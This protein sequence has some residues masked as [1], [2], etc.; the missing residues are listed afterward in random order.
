MSAFNPVLSI[1]A[2]IAEALRAHGRAGSRAAVRARVTDL[3]ASVGLGDPDRIRRAFPHELSGGQLQRAMIAMAISGE[4]EILIADEPT[5][6]LDVTVQ[7]GI[8]DLLR[9]VRER[10]GTAILLITH[11]MGV[12]A[13]LA[14][15]VVDLRQGRIVEQ[16][17]T[18]ELFAAAGHAYTR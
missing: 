10:L 5:T 11:D 12:V 14:D 9:S 18:R 4:P 6:A 1:G 13:D 8:L 2:Q 15:E 16:A 17:R 7:A 3:L